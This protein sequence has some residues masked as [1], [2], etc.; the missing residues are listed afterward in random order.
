MTQTRIIVLQRPEQPLETVCARLQGWGC[1]LVSCDSFDRAATALADSRLLHWASA[2]VLSELERTPEFTSWI[3]KNVSRR[4]QYLIG[5]LEDASAVFA[6][7]TGTRVE[8]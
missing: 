5:A 3:L 7:A 8:P 4:L 1:E 2:P 6:G